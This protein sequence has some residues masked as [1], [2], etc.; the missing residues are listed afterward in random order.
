MVEGRVKF[1]F[2]TTRLTKEDY[3]PIESELLKDYYRNSFLK[4]LDKVS[5]K[6]MH[7]YNKVREKK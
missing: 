4:L 6:I 5:N 7:L 3:S 2:P 1:Y